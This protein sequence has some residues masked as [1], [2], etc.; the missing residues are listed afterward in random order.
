MTKVAWLALFAGISVQAASPAE[1]IRAT[2]DRQVADWNRGDIDRFAEGYEHSTGTVF[3][4]S[5][6]SRGYDQMVARYKRSYGTPAKMG[7][8]TFSGLEINVLCGDWANVLGHF[9]LERD[10]AN[11]GNA[12]GVF[13]LLFHRTPAGWKIAQDHTS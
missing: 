11:G 6:V 7:K 5:T 10:A 3:V 13:T 12:D 1:E 2:L 8:L 9:H 4:G